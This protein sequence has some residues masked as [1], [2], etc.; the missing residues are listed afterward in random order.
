MKKRSRL[1]GDFLTAA[2]F[3]S[4]LPNDDRCFVPLPTFFWISGYRNSGAF[5]IGL[6]SVIFLFSPALRFPRWF[7]LPRCTRA[8]ISSL[9]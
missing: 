2:S 5:S 8:L 9:Y 4:G 1:S 7:S 6:A 3:L